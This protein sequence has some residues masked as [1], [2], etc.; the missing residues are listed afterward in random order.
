M[1]PQDA[2]NMID[3]PAHVIAA[4]KN[5]NDTD[6]NHMLD[7]IIAEEYCEDEVIPTLPPIDDKLAV[8]V[9]KWLRVRPAKDKIK[10]FFKQ[11]ML[12]SNVDGLKPVKINA[13]IYEKL[14]GDFKQNDQKLRGLNSFVT[15]GLGPLLNVWNQ[16]LKW[17]TAIT[18]QQNR[19]VSASM[20]VLHTGE[21]SLDLTDVRRQMDRAIRLLACCNS[22]LLDRHRQQLWPFFDNKFHYLLRESNPITSELLGDNIDQKVSESVKISEAAQKLQF[23]RSRGKP[24]FQSYGYR[25]SQGRGVRRPFN[26]RD[27]RHSQQYLTNSGAYQQYSQP[28]GYPQRPCARGRSSRGGYNRYNRG[29]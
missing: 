15:R 13:I 2:D 27:N 28:R 14:K 11:C 24:R 25:H 18:N 23:N 3:G 22:V 5:D 8:V 4:S 17:E 19:K 7:C 9:T 20:G 12:P 29:K 21:L 16:I 1:D 6:N 26:N 10:E